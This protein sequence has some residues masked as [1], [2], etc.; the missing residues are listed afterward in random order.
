MPFLY[1]PHTLPILS[2]YSPHTLLILS[3]YSPHTLLI[4]SSYSPHTLL[5]LSPYSPHTLPILSSYSPHTL[6]ILSSY[7]P[8]TKL[9]HSSYET[10]TLLIHSSYSLRN[11]GCGDNGDDWDTGRVQRRQT[12]MLRCNKICQMLLAGSVNWRQIVSISNLILPK[13]FF[14][15]H[16]KGGRLIKQKFPYL[17]FRNPCEPAKFFYRNKSIFVLFVLFADPL[18]QITCCPR[19]FACNILHILCIQYDTLRYPF[20]QILHKIVKTGRF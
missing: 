5:I 1:S 7:S 19:F 6:L 11:R 8:H 16:F 3:S 17:I 13:Q 9:I 18:Q 10:H 15:N 2:S 20:R 4:L 14:L 12:T